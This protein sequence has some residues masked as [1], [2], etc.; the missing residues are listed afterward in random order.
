MTQWTDD[1]EE[2]VALASLQA[3]TAGWAA[4]LY[5]VPEARYVNPAGG[6]RPEPRR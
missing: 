5:E 1:P 3:L 6:H 4:S 2:Q